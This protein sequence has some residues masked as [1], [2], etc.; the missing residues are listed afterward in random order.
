MDELDHRRVVG[1]V[2]RRFFLLLAA[3]FD[4]HAVEIDL[5]E[6]LHAAAGVVEELV[7]GLAELVVFDQQGFHRQPSAEL[8]VADGLLVGGVGDA[9]EQKVAAAQQRQ[10]AVLADQF[11]A[12][13]LLGLHLLIQRLQ[14]KQRQ[15]ELL[16]SHLGQRPRLD[17]LV[18]HQ[19]ADQ[20]DLVAQRFGLR[21]LGGLGIQQFGEHQLA[22]QAGEGDGVV[23]GEGNLLIRWLPYNAMPPSCQIP[24]MR[25]TK[26]GRSWRDWVRCPGVQPCAARE[27]QAL[28]NWHAIC[29]G[30]SRSARPLTF[31]RS[32]THE[33]ANA[34][35]V[36]SHRTDDCGCDHRYSGSHR[37]S[38]VS[39]LRC[40]VAS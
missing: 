11:L 16:G 38:S 31:S 4:I 30:L 32:N 7:D 18:L 6:I 3:L 22:G 13:Q 20:R 39:E 29:F 21:L 24:A 28:G 1:F 8:D 12:D 36:Y 35:R 34:E 2:G 37:H 17:Q 26:N 33:S 25:V 27:M 10:H 14:L 23:H 15:A 19:V 40:Q 9:D 5:A